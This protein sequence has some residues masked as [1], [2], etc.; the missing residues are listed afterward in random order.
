MSKLLSLTTL[1][2]V[3]LGGRAQRITLLEFEKEELI[4]SKKDVAH[5]II[6]LY[7]L[8]KLHNV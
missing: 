8:Q 4:V 2:I 6:T 3:V 5:D 1:T 7:H